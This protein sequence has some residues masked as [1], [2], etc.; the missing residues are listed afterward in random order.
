MAPPR[1]PDTAE[2]Q[3]AFLTALRRGAL[4]A[5]AALEAKVAIA[6]LYYWRGRDPLFAMAWESAA[7][8]SAEA[9]GRRLRF[10]ARRRGLFLTAFERS[11]NL[12]DACARTG[13]D[14]TTVYRLI[15]RDPEFERDC[16]AALERGGAALELALAAR[17]AEEARAMR[18]YEIVPRGTM[19]TDFEQIM[20]LLARYE[21]RDG[22]IGPRFVRHGRQQRWSFDDAIELLG[23][24]LKNMEPGW[25]GKGKKRHGTI[26]P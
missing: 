1:K 14:P 19:T 9:P 11:C 24:K 15:C 7:A 6:T 18:G 5:A 23:R 3:T 20:T 4:V 8:L 21:R 13:I 16:R 2:L 22:S 26:E 12:S 10:D 25:G 17:R